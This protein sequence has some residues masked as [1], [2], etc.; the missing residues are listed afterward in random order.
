MTITIDSEQLTKLIRDPLIVR[1]VSIIDVASLSI[2][3]LLEYN[4]TRN[5][6]NYALFNGVIAVDKSA[7]PSSAYEHA[8]PIEDLN[9]LVSGDY[10]FHNFLR[11]K[12]KLTEVGLYILES[13]GIAK[14][15]NNDI[16]LP[17]D[18]EE[19]NMDKF[20]NDIQRI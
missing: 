12:V 18:V 11:S 19:R 3:E 1:I 14:E 5:D 15:G 20:S 13:K 9:I 16:S 2:L 4:L 17:K 8:Q 10:Y 7:V 6:V